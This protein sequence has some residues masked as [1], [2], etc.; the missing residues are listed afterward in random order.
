MPSTT[1]TL[2]AFKQ[3]LHAAIAAAL[4]NVQVAYRWP[5]P[6]TKSEGIYLGDC[7][8]LSDINALT[9]GRTYRDE[10]YRVQVICQSYRAANRPTDAATADERV[11]E[12]FAAVENVIA[13]DTRMNDT[14]AWSL[15][16]T[17]E[18]ET[19]EFEPGVGIR[20]TAVVLV[21]ARLI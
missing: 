13:D 1:S 5:G 3:S 10:H 17:F 2:A 6:S 11:L 20:L 19:F 21:E 7:S 16:E 12:L 15:I 9:E 4:P 18:T 14:V 8:G